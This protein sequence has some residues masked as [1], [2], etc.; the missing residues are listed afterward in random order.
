MATWPA[1]EH[2]RGD[3]N[4]YSLQLTSG[5]DPLDLHGVRVR[6]TVK[7]VG[8]TSDPDDATDGNAVLAHELYVSPAGT[9][10]TEHGLHV[11][12]W[13]DG[14]LVSDLA[15]GVITHRLPE[16]ESAALEPNTYVYDI[17]VRD[18]AGRV[19][20]KINGASWTVTEDVTRKPV[21]P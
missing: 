20:T 15:Q 17:E 16:A 10:T 19:D 3:T 8:H 9:V 4:E 13:R 1:V 6:L 21:T 14:V 12:G 5:L 11:G 7:P 18:A 2:A